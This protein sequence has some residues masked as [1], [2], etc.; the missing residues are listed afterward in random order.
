MSRS[1]NSS[2]QGTKHGLSSNA[3]ARGA[4]LAAHAGLPLDQL[5]GTILVAGLLLIPPFLLA[6]GARE[7]FRAPKLYASGWLALASLLALSWGLRRV[8]RIDLAALRRLPALAAVLP[9]LALATLSLAATEHPIQVREGLTDLW[10]GAACLVGWS[11]ALPAPRLERL[12]AVSLLP[13]ALLALVGVLQ[14]YDL[15]QP[16]ALLGLKAGERLA[17]TS[18][19]GNPGDLGAYLVLPCLI[20]QRE[21][22]RRWRGGEPRS[23][24]G[25]ALFSLVALLGALCLAG[26]VLTQTLAALGAYG[27]GTIVFWTL[28]LPRRR[29]L[30][31]LGG[32]LAL[33]LALA[34]AVAPLRQRLA[35]KLEQ[36]RQGSLNEVLSG[37]LDGWQ[38]AVWMLGQHPLT[39]VG[40][41]AFRPS[42]IPAKLALLERGRSFSHEQMQVVFANAHSEPLE[43]A[44]DLGLPGLAALGW[45]LWVVGRRLR[46][47]PSAASRTA[48]PV[49]PDGR[50]LA[51]GGVA[52]L[53]VL[54]LA[55]FPFR[56]ALVAF[57][58]LL[59]LSWVLHPSAG[60][61]A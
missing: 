14:Y 5:L 50:A 9:F 21:L 7:A 13:S 19:A 29:A 11:A 40:H 58:A 16:L 12:L 39:G 2:R 45:G 4:E 59:F 47:S 15:W 37:R 41:G 27:V 3:G 54:S 26:L 30:L 31:L 34:A 25:L 52:A 33:V 48:A 8:P 38:A 46:R 17:V 60:E 57:P 6:L 28:A 51:W 61:V 1:K 43:V 35:L 20:A 24:A 53:L 22:L 32:G 36:M 44:A 55:Y 42:F 18:F 49:E 10:I 23:P 56:V